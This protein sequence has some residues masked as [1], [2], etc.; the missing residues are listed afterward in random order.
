MVYYHKLSSLSA[1]L[2]RFNHHIA[3]CALV[4]GVEGEILVSNPINTFNLDPWKTEWTLELG[5]N[6]NL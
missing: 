1:K 2:L 3:S 5:G 6:S 4:I